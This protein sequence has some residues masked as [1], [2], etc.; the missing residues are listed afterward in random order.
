MYSFT[1]QKNKKKLNNHKQNFV[2]NSTYNCWINKTS[3]L[4]R[5]ICTN[6][7]AYINECNIEYLLNNVIYHYIKKLNRVLLKK[8]QK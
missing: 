5:N 7:E 6:L 2:M 3:K 1:V 4:Y 8:N